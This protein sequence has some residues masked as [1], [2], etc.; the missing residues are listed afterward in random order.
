MQQRHNDRR[1]Y[2][3][4]LAQTSSS[5]YVDYV[6]E[7]I[8]L[9]ST[10]R[11]LEVGCGEGGNLLPFACLGAKVMGI[12]LY[13]ERIEQAQTYFKESG[14]KGIF[15]NIDFFQLSEPVRSE[16]KFDLV[17]VHDIIENIEPDMKKEFVRKVGS[18]VKSTGI[19]FFRFPAWQMPFGGHQ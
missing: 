11:I 12:D 4:E 18:F 17:L 3:S 14:Q 10:T 15:R 13:G 16:E 6:K 9:D 7:Y 8:S 5:F 19:I 2:F 1:R